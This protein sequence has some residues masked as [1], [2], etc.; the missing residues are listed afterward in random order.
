MTAETSS[1]HLV[2]L[3]GGRG[4]RMGGIDKGL[5]TL[6]GQTF[7]ETLIN[8][9]RNSSCPPQQIII[10]ANR[11]QAEYSRLACRVV[12]DGRSGFCGPLAGI[13]S[14]LPFC[15]NSP[16]VVVPG[17]SPK[18][19]AELP[20][21]LASKL[22]PENFISVAHDGRQLQP[23]M[24]AFHAAHWRQSLTDYLD[25]GGRS[26]HGWLKTANTRSVVFDQAANFSNIN[27]RYE[28]LQ[29]VNAINQPGNFPAIRGCSNTKIQVLSRECA[30]KTQNMPSPA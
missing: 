13:E 10:S 2:I 19:C 26:V 15:D 25:R 11:H 8:R 29:L 23:L 6:Q 24:M 12:A 9:F 1:Y 20:L 18:I 5:L 3:C 17:D 30:H 4:S 21:I 16:V 22:G 7:T 14:C 27:E 28:Y